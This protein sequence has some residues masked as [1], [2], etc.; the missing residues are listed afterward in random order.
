MEP[1]QSLSLNVMSWRTEE[2]NR[3][4]FTG[5]V[6]GRTLR[7]TNLLRIDL[8]EQVKASTKMRSISMEKDQSMYSLPF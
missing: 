4:A 3:T 1:S 8:P 2:R 7:V 5:N 6:S